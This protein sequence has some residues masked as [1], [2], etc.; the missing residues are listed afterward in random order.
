MDVPEHGSLTEFLTS[1]ARML[2]EG[3]GQGLRILVAFDRGGSFPAELAELRDLGIEFVTYERKPYPSLRRREF[4]EKVTI[5]GEVYWL[6]ESRKKNLGKGRG[7]VRRIC[8]L[9]PEG[10]QV[11]LLAVSEEPAR[12]LLEVMVGRWVQE[13]GFKHGVERWGINQL[14]GRKVEPYA[15][16]TVIPNPARRR[17]ENALRLARQREGDAR[18]K[19]A[20][21]KTGENGDKLREKL[22]RDLA[23]AT[24]AQERL[25]E[26][27]P[28]V[29][30]EIPLSESELAG[31]LVYH[32]SHYKTVLDTVRLACINAESDLAAIL[33]PHLSKPAEAKKALANLFASIGDIYVSDRVIRVKLSPA[34]RKDELEAFKAFFDEINRRNLTLPGDI[35]RRPLIFSLH[36]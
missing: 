1:M 10:N 9:T 11:N 5:D 12:R 30:K 16:G 22:E 17:L 24:V 7:R 18:R 36:L 3:L 19:L 28:S 4:K 32:K 23:E 6:H 13:N 15:P 34:G 27:R 2:Q 8:V 21:L 26:Q 25:M 20:H 33:A 35:H 31:K 14:D 29:P